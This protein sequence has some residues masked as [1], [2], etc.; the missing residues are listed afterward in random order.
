MSDRLITPYEQIGGAETLSR[1]VDAFYDLVAKHPD[2]A[3]LFPDDF[4]EVKE[5]QYQFLTQFLGGPTLYSDQ[6]G[7]PMLRA[8]H[9]R[10]PIGAVQAEAWLSCMSKAMDQIALAGELRDQIFDRL[11][12]TAYHMVNQWEKDKA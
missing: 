3:P 1:L 2:L 11:R 10:F 7:H 4:T 12:L 6:H 9:M 8:R 5:R